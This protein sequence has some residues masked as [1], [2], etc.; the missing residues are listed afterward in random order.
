MQLAPRSDLSQLDSGHQ[1]LALLVLSCWR[2][3]EQPSL[4]RLHWL[5]HL[6]EICG[7]Q[8]GVIPGPGCHIPSRPKATAAPPLKLQGYGICTGLSSLSLQI[9]LATSQTP[10]GGTFNPGDKV[11][12]WVSGRHMRVVLDLF[13]TRALCCAWHQGGNEST[14]SRLTWHSA[15][16]APRGQRVHSHISHGRGGGGGDSS[17][18]SPGL[19]A[20][21]E[22]VADEGLELHA[23]FE[24]LASWPL[25]VCAVRFLTVLPWLGSRRS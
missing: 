14:L 2:S 22:E 17:A 15:V 7:E 11:A 19:L 1:L 25:E 16:L 6:E 18:S 13:T 10:L 21:R 8:I 20:P 5:R 9:D 4:D 3:Y 23:G 12:V 24:A